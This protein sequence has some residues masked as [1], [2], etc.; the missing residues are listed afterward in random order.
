MT[1]IKANKLL[2]S[3]LSGQLRE[4]GERIRIARKRRRLTTEEMSKRMFVS[5]RTLF[6]L[7]QGEPGISLGV[8]ASALW[9]LGLDK[10]WLKLADSEQDQVG[11]FHERQRLPQRV[12]SKSPNQELDF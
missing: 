3:E 12:R 7:E 11:I 10:D 6:R 2:T 8:L 1:Q 9:T 4:L 5:R